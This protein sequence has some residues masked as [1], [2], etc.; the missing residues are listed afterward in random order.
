V[1]IVNNGQVELYVKEE[2]LSG[3]KRDHVPY[4]AL[5]EIL[6]RNT[7]PI[8]YICTL[9]PTGMMSGLNILPKKILRCP[10][11]NYYHQHHLSHASL[12]F[13]NSGFDQALV[14][15][16]DRLGSSFSDDLNESETVFLASY[17]C[18][19]RVLQKNLWKG[20]TNFTIPSQANVQEDT[21]HV[22]INNDNTMSI[23]KVYETA[24]TLIGQHCLENGKTMGLAGYGR[25]QEF[26]NFFD[27]HLPRDNLFVEGNFVRG[28]DTKSCL[29]KG[30]EQL[31]I[32]QVDKNNY[33]FYADY[34]YQVQKQT[35]EQVLQLI[36]RW[37]DKTGVKKVCISGGY[38][39]NVVT[40]GYLIDQLPQ[41]EFYFEPMADDSGIS[42]GSAMHLYREK[43]KDQTVKPLQH[44]FF[45]GL[46]QEITS[47]GDNCSEEDIA[48]FLI[49]QKIVAVFTG[50][51]EAGPRA[52]GHRSILFDARNPEAKR[53]VNLVKNREWYRPFAGVVLEKDFDKYFHNKGLQN[54]KL[55]TISFDTK[56]PQLIPGITHVDNSCR[57]Q[58][59]NED[60]PHLHKLLTAFKHNTGCSVLL[61]TSFNLAGQPLIET[62]Q[63]AIHTFYQSKI[64]I[65]WFPEI[66]KYLKKTNILPSEMLAG[67]DAA[68][69]DILD[70]SSL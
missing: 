21:N 55:M 40:N 24:T 11:V 43:S 39:L 41:I 44:L 54:S 59:V 37:I 45:Q 12:A 38:G 31:L 3:I 52:L 15:V 34:A 5:Y 29:F 26:V 32:M 64:D 58:T 69:S 7:T 65:L 36:Q 56:L 62:Q 60:I 9:V 53:I 46:P 61:N 23:T 48:N 25:N 57:V 20:K 13:Y 2:R 22:V 63:Q 4:Q 68:V 51:S 67:Y 28:S 70:Y 17:P 27:N 30:H 14:V 16:M 66:N 33:Q 8:D 6:K 1:A 49:E 42:I 35:Q 19:F 10:I 18:N 47:L 50:M